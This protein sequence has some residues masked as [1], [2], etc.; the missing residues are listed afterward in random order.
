MQKVCSVCGVLKGLEMFS[1]Q[2]LGKHGK[3]ANC[4]K[5][6]S[7]YKK[8]Y[9]KENREN[10]QT[11][12]NIRRSL[13]PEKYRE[14]ERERYKRQI[15]YYRGKVKRWRD[16]N[17]EKYA[18]SMRRSSKKYVENVADGYAKKMMFGQ[19]AKISP[20]KELIEAYRIYLKVKRLAKEQL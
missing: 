8:R 14:K 1:A 15:E 16:A 10:I 2:K 7:E 20:P 9:E 4:K 13:N 6:D 11:K 19:G 12:K 18:E 17:P 3:R 5:C